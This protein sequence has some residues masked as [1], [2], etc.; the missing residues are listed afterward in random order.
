MVSVHDLRTDETTQSAMM[1]RFR[2]IIRNEANSLSGAVLSSRE[3]AAESLWLL[4]QPGVELATW[5][6]RDPLTGRTHTV[7][8]LRIPLVVMEF[9][10]QRLTERVETRSTTLTL[11][12]GATAIGWAVSLGLLALGDRLTLGYRRRWLIP[13]GLGIPLAATVTGWWHLWHTNLCGR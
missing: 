12:A 7:M 6:R 10:K 4:R 5:D 9:W 2:E 11:G 1:K 8:Q 3:A 13:L